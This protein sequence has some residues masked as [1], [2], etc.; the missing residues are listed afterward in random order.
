MEGSRTIQSSLL[1]V[2]SVFK[3]QLWSRNI[4]WKRLGVKNVMSAECFCRGCPL[5]ICYLPTTQDPTIHRSHCQSH[6]FL[7]NVSN[8]HKVLPLVKK[9][10]GLYFIRKAHI[11]VAAMLVGKTISTHETVKERKDIS[12]SFVAR[13]HTTKVV[14]TSYGA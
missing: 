14:H 1:P 8:K 10:K 13:P 7:T 6:T 2:D 12:V 3:D 11:E 5:C 9:K 4:S